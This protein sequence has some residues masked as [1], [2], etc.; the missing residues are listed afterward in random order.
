MKYIIDIN[1]ETVELTKD[2]VTKIYIDLEPYFVAI[3]EG[4]NDQE[5]EAFVSEYRSFLNVLD[6][7][8]SDSQENSNS[9]ETQD[10]NEE[11]RVCTVYDFLTRKEVS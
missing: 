5:T 11:L 7:V 3:Q 2:Q 6:A 9:C 10:P 1:G 8:G 4:L